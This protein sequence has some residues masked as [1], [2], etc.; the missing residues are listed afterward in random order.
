MMNTTF[1]ILKSKTMVNFVK[2]LFIILVLIL[3]G[4]EVKE[5]PNIMIIMVDDMGYSDPGCYGGEIQTPNIDYLAE[6]GVRLTN[7]YNCS[8]CCPSRASLLT[9]QYQHN[10]GLTFNGE[11][12]TKN[13]VTIAEVL[14]EAGYQTGMT[15]KWHLSKTVVKQEKTEQLD[16]LAN[17]INGGDFADINTYPCNRGFD[18]HFGVIWGVVNYFNP[19]SLVH[20]EEP[21]KNIPEDFYMTDYVTDKTLDL[22]DKFSKKEQP[23]FM[24]VAHTAPHWPLH[25]LPED[26]DKYKGKYNSGWDELR[27]NRYSRMIDMGIFDKES[28]PK[29]E[30]T[31]GLKWDSIENKEWEAA[32]MEVHAAMVDHVDQGVGKILNKLKAIGELD[33]TVIFFMSDNGASPERVIKAGYDRPAYTRDSTRIY[34]VNDGYARPGGETTMAGLGKGWAGA[35][36]TPFRYWKATE[37]H[38]G[39]ATP[40]II[41][42]PKGLVL[43]KGSINKTE[44]AHVMDIMPTCLDIA[45]TEY[46]NTYHGN[47]IDPLDGRSL[48]PFI[49]GTK[50]KGYDVMFWEHEGNKAVRKGSWKLVALKGGKWKLYDLSKDISETDDLSSQYPDQVE[51]MQ[52]LYNSWAAKMKLKD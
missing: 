19:F 9:G 52:K 48:L 33:N 21:V 12:L 40:F 49:K 28:T 17:R 44:L 37:Y 6:E 13:C 30:N 26:I 22:I 15:G 43:K 2:T 23:F 31:S 51:E 47:K 27:K 39:N 16:W 4:C 20:N 46:P 34:Y 10:V 3:S 14:K 50:R 24:Y 5:K 8:R 45:G 29:A 11:S 38:G 32:H 7:F 36:N 35:V 25:A 42:W 41:Y 18:E 1:E